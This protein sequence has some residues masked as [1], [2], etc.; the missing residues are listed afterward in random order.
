MTVLKLLNIRTVSLKW[1][2][3]IF[4]YCLTFLEDLSFM[5]SQTTKCIK[6]FP[7]VF[8]NYI[9]YASKKILSGTF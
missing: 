7:S 8:K 6:T 4:F 2:T 3:F 1:S 9:D 5:V